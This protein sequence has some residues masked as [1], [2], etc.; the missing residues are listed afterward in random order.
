MREIKV[1]LLWHN[2]NSNNYGVG[3]L[4]ISHVALLQGAAEQLGVK[5]C[6][7]TL[8][9]RNMAGLKVAEET[10]LL[11]GVEIKHVDYSLRDLVSGMRRFNFEMVKLFR[12]YDIV[13]DIGEGDSFTDLYGVRRFSIQ[14]ATKLFTV[15][16][17]VPLVIAPQTI[18]PFK[19]AYA[20]KSA[21]WILKKARSVYTRDEASANF[22]RELGVTPTAL[23]DVAFSLPYSQGARIPNSV[24]INVSGLLFS[25]GYTK[26]NQFG[27]T[28]DYPEFVTQL[29]SFFRSMGQTVHLVGHVIAPNNEV[30][31]DYRACEKVKQAFAEDDGVVV[32]KAF[33]SPIEA[34]SYISQLSF[35]VGSRMHATIASVSSGVPTV[36][37]AYSKKFGSLF[38]G[39]GYSCTLDA[40]S[41]STEELLAATKDL[42]LNK[43]DELDQMAKAAKEQSGGILS[44]YRA[45]LAGELENV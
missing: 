26:T 29:T 12:R 39:V 16:A 28:V 20:R 34:K 33:A 24:G 38:E 10:E 31:D 17:G 37:V 36:P 7:E 15:M 6:F 2:L 8:G 40:R 1:G 35:F 32:A 45:K 19:A 25:G 4:A 18:G 14:M 9:T 30:E 44:D 13:F 27:L 11:L 43:Y 41:S 22:A 3:A 42:F 23:T 5:L 21:G